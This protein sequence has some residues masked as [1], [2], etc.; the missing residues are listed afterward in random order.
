VHY[1][2]SQDPANGTNPEPD[3]SNPHPTFHVFKKVNIMLPTK[4]ST[5]YHQI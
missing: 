5:V 1:L 4:S 3:E 2:V